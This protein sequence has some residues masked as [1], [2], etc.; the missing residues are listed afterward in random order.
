MEQHYILSTTQL[1]KLADDAANSWASFIE[2]M[3]PELEKATPKL[4]PVEV[5]RVLARAIR[6]SSSPEGKEIVN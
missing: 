1:M 4:S 2:D 5:C 3:A 6:L